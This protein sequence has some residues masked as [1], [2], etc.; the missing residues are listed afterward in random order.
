MGINSKFGD[1]LSF[2]FYNFYSFMFFNLIPYLFIFTFT[3]FIFGDVTFS[4]KYSIIRYFETFGRELSILLLGISLGIILSGL[5]MKV[6]PSKSTL[7]QL[8]MNSFLHKLLILFPAVVFLV[9][10]KFGYS[11]VY[12]DEL[13]IFIVIFIIFSLINYV[14]ITILRE[15]NK[16]SKITDDYNIGSYWVNSTYI[17]YRKIPSIMNLFLFLL[18]TLD[19][20]FNTKKFMS[21]VIGLQHFGD[22][23]DWYG[24]NYEVITFTTTFLIISIQIL[25]LNTILFLSH[26]IIKIKSKPI[27]ILELKP[28]EISKN[29]LLK[30]SLAVLFLF[31]IF[32]FTISRIFPI[33]EGEKI[34]FLWSPF[35]ANSSEINIKPSISHWFGTDIFG[36][37]IFS[38][39]LFSI[40][41]MFVIIAIIL[42]ILFIL[43]IV[44]K[45]FIHSSKS[46]ESNNFYYAIANF[47]SLPI[48]IVIAGYILASSYRGN[49]LLILLLYVIIFWPRYI[50][51]IEYDSDTV[52]YINLLIRHLRTIIPK[53][54][55]DITLIGFLG[56]LPTDSLNLGLMLRSFMSGESYIYWWNWLFPLLFLYLIFSLLGKE[57]RFVKST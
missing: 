5:I 14:S 34:M 33:G 15:F 28:S 54:I 35:Y 23:F 45:K 1:I 27:P 43:F 44:F 56:L 20:H 17:V 26:S 10:G 51:R 32:I 47:T 30:I 50:K 55:F 46:D 18:I 49:M 16:N 3:P 21:N 31:S 48:L 8:W 13:S 11:L 39:V 38:M 25:I 7:N 57:N 53:I 36:R 37:D 24:S 42:F 29:R 6:I 2:I 52:N 40:S 4:V 12:D 22:L 9:V 41:E 19:L